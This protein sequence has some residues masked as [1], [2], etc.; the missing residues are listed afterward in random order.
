MARGS[1]GKAIPVKQFWSTVLVPPGAVVGCALAGSQLEG[2]QSPQRRQGGVELQRLRF[3]RRAGG[4]EI[5]P[6][7]HQLR[8][9]G[10]DVRAARGRRW[11][12]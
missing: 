11:G 7:A 6:L 2:S 9:A 8:A 10:G 4:V 3:I 1:A 12:A 5:T